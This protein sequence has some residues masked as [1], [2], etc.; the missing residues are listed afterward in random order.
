[1]ASG[2]IASSPS[3]CESRPGWPWLPI[4]RAMASS[5]TGRRSKPSGP[6]EPGTPA[7]PA[8]SRALLQGG[9]DLF[10]DEV[11][12]LEDRGK[13]AVAHLEGDVTAASRLIGAQLAK[14]VPDGAAQHVA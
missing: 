7:R 2:S 5:S 1:M 4:A 11:Q 13:G 6:P 12:G 10:D 3:R 14:H 9:A 8:S